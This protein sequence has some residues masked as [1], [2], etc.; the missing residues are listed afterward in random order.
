MFLFRFTLLMIMRA[1]SCSLIF[2]NYFR[3]CNAR[4]SYCQW[5]YFLLIFIE[6]LRS[7]YRSIN[8]F[9]LLKSFQSLREFHFNDTL[10]TAA[11]HA[12]GT[13]TNVFIYL[14]EK[15]HTRVWIIF[16]IWV[17]NKITSLYALNVY[18]DIIFVNSKFI[19]FDTISFIY[20][21]EF[22]EKCVLGN[23]SWFFF[24]TTFLLIATIIFLISSSHWSELSNKVANKFVEIWYILLFFLFF[25]RRVLLLLGSCANLR[26]RRSSWT[27]RSGIRQKFT[28]AR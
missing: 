5:K 12:T 24:F 9:F 26:S 1:N 14:S 13:D 2:S 4:C 27:M 11:R 8:F 23:I 16:I 25:S 28:F 17:V 10:D 20:F 7:I 21:G 18:N 3:Y 22:N 15:D 19:S 6:K